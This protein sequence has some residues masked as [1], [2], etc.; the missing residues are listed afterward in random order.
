MTALRHF[1]PFKFD[2][3]KAELPVTDLCRHPV[4]SLPNLIGNNHLIYAFMHLIFSK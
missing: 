1:T 4:A 2:H 3:L